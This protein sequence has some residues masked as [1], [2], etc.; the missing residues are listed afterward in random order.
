MRVVA[1]P[2]RYAAVRYKAAELPHARQPGAQVQWA[3]KKQPRR[4]ELFCNTVPQTRMHRCHAQLGPKKVHLAVRTKDV[5]P[6]DVRVLRF[7]RAPAQLPCRLHRT[8]PTAV[9]THPTQHMR[10][11]YVHNHTA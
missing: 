10:A 5:L 9:T 3:R 8:V 11:Y 1:I 4:W 7:R 6:D 2:R